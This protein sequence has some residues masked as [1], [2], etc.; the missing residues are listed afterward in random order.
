[1]TKQ[2]TPLKESKIKPAMSTYVM[3]QSLEVD[4]EIGGKIY[5]LKKGDVVKVV[6]YDEDNGL[7][8]LNINGKVYTT[9]DLLDTAKFNKGIKL[10]IVEYKK[11]GPTKAQTKKVGKVMH[12]WKAGKLVIK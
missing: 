4:A 11:G 10:K 3:T 12:E 1:M 9:Y 6:E 7:A 5:K 8:F 2:Y